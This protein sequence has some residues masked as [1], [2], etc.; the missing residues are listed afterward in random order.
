MIASGDLHPQMPEWEGYDAYVA[1]GGYAT[2][3]DI[4][5]NGDPE[6]LQDKV[7]ESG[8]RGPGGAGFPSGRKWSFVRMNEGTKYL[9]VNGD[10]ANRE[11]KTLLPRTHPHC[12]SRAC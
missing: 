8:L 3:K 10:E 6:A 1:G 7:L 9:A 4:R 2:L 12:S 5:E 11:L